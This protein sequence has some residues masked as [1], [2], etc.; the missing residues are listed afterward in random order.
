MDFCWQSSVSAF[1][2]LSMLVITFL[3]RSKCP[4][5]SWLQSPSTEILE[6]KKII[7]HCFHF[8]LFSPRTTTTRANNGGTHSLHWTL[9]LLSMFQALVHLTLITALAGKYYYCLQ[10]T[11]TNWGS[12][13]SRLYTII[14]LI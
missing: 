13:T 3:P 4:L 12:S 8:P 7:R 9:C 1:N 14:L 2:M 11:V 6:P 5:I 10:F